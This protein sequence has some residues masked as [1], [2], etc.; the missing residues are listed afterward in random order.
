M[1]TTFE[2]LSIIISTIFLFVSIFGVYLKLKIDITKVDMRINGINRELLQKEISSLL[3]EKINREDHEKIL[4]K[5]DH[6]IE[7]YTK[8]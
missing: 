4:S 1:M 8:S 7:I 6:L 2:I 3:S 5:I